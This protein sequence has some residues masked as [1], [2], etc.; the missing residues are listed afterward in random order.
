MS[1]PLEA[2]PSSIWKLEVFS[3]Y[4]FMVFTEATRDSELRNIFH[5][6]LYGVYATHSGTVV[7]P[8][9]P[10]RVQRWFTVGGKA[11][12]RNPPFPSQSPLKANPNIVNCQFPTSDT[13]PVQYPKQPNTPKPIIYFPW[14]HPMWHPSLAMQMC[15]LSIHLVLLI[16]ILDPSLSQRDFALP[17]RELNADALKKH[18]IRNVSNPHSSGCWHLS[19]IG[20]ILTHIGAFFLQTDEHTSKNKSNNNERNQ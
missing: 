12:K 11:C 13:Y 2:P 7:S 3:W 15:R 20:N 6:F 17:S 10:R 1:V 5:I 4:G 14:K 18:C 19:F 16:P 9:S 8:S